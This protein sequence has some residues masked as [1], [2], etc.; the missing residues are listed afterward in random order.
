MATYNLRYVKAI[1][2]KGVLGYDV[3]ITIIF[4]VIKLFHGRF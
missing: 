3:E 1:T 4:G 2:S